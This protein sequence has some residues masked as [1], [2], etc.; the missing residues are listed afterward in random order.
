M[1]FEI[2]ARDAA[3]R[4]GKFSTRHG[5]ITTPTLLPVINPNK[6]LIT[7]KEMQQLFG[8]DIIITN[9][10][11]IHKDTQLSTQALDRGVH[12]LLEFPK[13]IMTD[14]GTFQ[15]YIYG[16]IAVDPLE[17]IEF[18]RDIG[19]DIGTI[20]DIFSTPDHTKEQAQQ[21][22]KE[23]IIRAKISIPLK[24]NMLIACPIQGSIYPK[25]R[26]QC[27][28]EL[29]K[30]AAD[31]YPIGGVVPLMENQQYTELATAIIAAKQGLDPSKP[32]HLFGAGHPLLFPLAVA[33]GCDLFDS[34]S[35]AKYANAGRMLFPWGT[36][37]LTNLT[38][39]P[40]TCPICN[41]YTASELQKEEKK[42]QIRAL[43]IHNLYICYAEL[44]RVKNAITTG[45][46]WKLVE[47]RASTTP[48]LHDALMQLKQKKHSTWLEQYE[49]ISKTKG[50]IYTGSY[51]IYQ[52]L[53]YRLYQR[54]LTHYT[55]PSNTAVIFPT[56]TT[57][58]STY[59]HFDILSML[60]SSPDITLLV[61]S[62]YGIIPLELDEM[63][64]LAQSEFPLT[65]DLETTK[66]RNQFTRKF[67]EKFTLKER[68]SYQASRPSNNIA[69]LQQ[70][71]D[72]RRIQSVADIQFRPTAGKSLLHH[73]VSFKKSK[74]TGKIRQIYSQDHHVLS[75][76]AHD[77]LFTLKID[78]GKILHNNLTSP[79][80]RLIVDDEAIP[81][82]LDGKSV[83]SKFVI[84][85][86]PELRPY[87][88]CLIV[89]KKD[90]LL[91]VGRCL[92]T[93]WE[94]T[95]FTNGVAAK[96]RESIKN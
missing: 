68:K 42:D 40:C 44:R 21:A 53:I 57:P 7:P 56:T 10:Y 55:P 63:Y 61:N 93:A 43:A 79:S 60:H 65:V 32:V 31:V 91:A 49:P 48:H 20:L 45:T 13:T 84:K 16:T 54:L 62:P 8:T 86:D 19:S 72:I 9:S 18:Q 88:E 74:K 87:D 33:L 70:L 11:I 71:W 52:P 28:Q 15:S 23:T 41:S 95:H 47:E 94:I 73:P 58:Y 59:Y 34:A 12:R 76:R 26:K 38:E 2:K 67:L 51:T 3:G 64:P 96:T 17:I 50:L 36:E 24:Q 69:N 85:S 89:D 27:A 80:L 75:M 37:H 81:F 29:S 5:V 83:F 77:G 30:L 66:V 35:Y 14:S 78:G 1:P 25:L 90:R 22:V 6:Q 39:L 82:V 4:I 92:L 46:L